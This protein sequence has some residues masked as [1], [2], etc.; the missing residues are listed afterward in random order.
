MMNPAMMAKNIGVAATRSPFEIG[1]EGDLIYAIK[2][3]MT[4]PIA[5]K[6]N[7]CDIAVATANL[8]EGRF[9]PATI[10]AVMLNRKSPKP[11]RWFKI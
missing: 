3:D 2:I 10:P 6:I 1:P 8:S 4:E 9:V 7:I 11:L 5:K